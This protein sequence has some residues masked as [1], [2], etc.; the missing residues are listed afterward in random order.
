MIITIFYF[1]R[2]KYFLCSSEQLHWL[3]FE[4]NSSSL[5]FD[6]RVWLCRT[7]EL[8]PSDSGQLSP[9]GSSS[10]PS[11]PD[12]SGSPD[13]ISAEGT[14]FLDPY[15]PGGRPIDGTIRPPPAQ[16]NMAPPVGV[17]NMQQPFTHQLPFVN[18]SAGHHLSLFSDSG[19]ISSRQAKPSFEQP[20]TGKCCFSNHDAVSFFSLLIKIIAY[21][22]SQ[23]P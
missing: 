16:H 7:K 23:Y 22:R 2:C 12:D 5:N 6:C 13:G 21:I 20:V 15:I 17:I 18:S 11:P 4:C 10:N 1:E 19:F 8:S 9:A 3:N 14:T